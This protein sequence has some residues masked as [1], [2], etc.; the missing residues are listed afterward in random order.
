MRLAELR[1]RPLPGFGAIDFLSLPAA[2]AAGAGPVSRLPHSL[3]VLVEH[4]LRQGSGTAR[5]LDLVRAVTGARSEGGTVAF[6][7]GRILLQDA[8]GLPVLADL[9]ALQDAVREAGGDAERAL[10]RLPM[11][12]V[13]DHAVEVDHWG[14][15]AARERNLARERERHADRYR[16]LRWSGTRLPGLRVVPPGTGICHQLNL[17][18]LATVVTVTAPSAGRPLAGF[19]SVLGTD[20]H[21]TMVNALSVLGWGVGGIEATA[22]V[23]GEP[24]DM[25]IP[26]VVGVRLTG[27]LQAGTL[28]SD[29]ALSLTARLRAHNV[30]HKIV[31]F[32][33]PALSSLPVA[34]RATIA[35]M[36]PEYGATMAYFPADAHTLTYLRTT[37]RTDA[38]VALVRAYLEAQG[39]LTHQGDVEPDF[40][41]VIEFDLSAIGST[42]AGPHR[43]DQKLTLSQLPATVPTRATTGHLDGLTDGDVVIAAITSCTNTSNPRALV[44]AGL[45]ARKA[46]RL[47]IAPPPWTKTSLAPG[48]QAASRLLD[49]TGLQTYLDKLGFHLVG[50]G[51]TTCMGNSGPLHATLE[52]QITDNGLSVAA[53]LSGNR[54]FEGRI[55]PQ[56]RLSYLASPPLVVALALAGTVTVDLTTRPLT[57]T[58]DGRDVLLADLW[59]TEAEIDEV[60]ASADMRELHVA[61]R[62]TQTTWDGEEYPGDAHRTYPWD[63]EAGF[64]RQ[65]PFLEPALTRPLVSTD[66]QGA[67][68]L[69]IL[70]DHVTTDHIS[71]ISR[72]T[73]ESPAGSWLL[74][75]GVAPDRLTGYAARRLNHDVMVR[76]AFTNPRIHNLLLPRPTGGATRVMPDGEEVPIH[77]AATRYAERNVPVVVIAGDGYGTGSARDWAAKAT[78]M[79]GVRAVIAKSFERIHRTNLVAMGILPLQLPTGFDLTLHGHETLDISGVADAVH[80][81]GSATL[82]I[83][84]GT[85]TISWITVDSRVETATETAWLRHGGLLPKIFADATT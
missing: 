52:Q 16:F 54:N 38:H 64:I 44:A 83:A 85:R 14:G 29:I 31:E 27:R 77:V 81:G 78:R 32:C 73:P 72:I 53:V 70:G 48:S 66:I 55:H 35:N 57:R 82:R 24:I 18:Q 8:S 59:P 56:V 84:D 25:R 20:S 75:R 22:A 42:L 6:L 67:R 26:E 4:L 50:H 3:R 60:I 39:M 49:A 21:T 17:E 47:G 46:A 43:P 80:P 12:L 68:P 10:P 76:G 45:L 58:P 13:V 23:L 69:L 9:I 65:P 15:P 28:A 61:A 2:E 63:G 11:D 33:G 7:P 34:D 19:D 74:R 79:L 36:A 71:P 62:H 37:G 30:V 40:D 41:D 1:P 51:C 5:T